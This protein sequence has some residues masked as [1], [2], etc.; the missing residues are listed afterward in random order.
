MIVTSATGC[1]LPP[2]LLQDIPVD[3]SAAAA[4]PVAAAAAGAAQCC[5]RLPLVHPEPRHTALKPWQAPETAM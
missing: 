4:A 3:I 1:M 5:C 2:Y